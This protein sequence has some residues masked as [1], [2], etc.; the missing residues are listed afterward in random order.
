MNAKHG[1]HR[2]FHG[3]L[4]FAGAA[5]DLVQSVRRACSDMNWATD[6]E[7]VE[8]YFRTISGG[9]PIDAGTVYVFW[10]PCPSVDCRR[11]QNVQAE[12]RSRR[13]DGT[14]IVLSYRHGHE[15]RA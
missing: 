10:E 14:R 8:R 7:A 13:D 6:A 2:E 3:R 12:V 11:P 4:N 1:L 15:A 9:I 5:Q